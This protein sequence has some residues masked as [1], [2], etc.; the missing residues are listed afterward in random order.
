MKIRSTDTGERVEEFNFS[1]TWDWFFDILDSQIVRAMEHRSFHP[2][3]RFL[4]RA[5]E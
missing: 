4:L 5:F 3:R 1:R 2:A